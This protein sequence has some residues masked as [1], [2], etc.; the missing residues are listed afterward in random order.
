[1]GVELL[2]ATRF[3]TAPTMPNTLRFDRVL[4]MSSANFSDG[5]NRSFGGKYLELCVQEGTGERGFGRSFRAASVPSR[6]F[7]RRG[8]C[9]VPQAVLIVGWVAQYPSAT[10]DSAGVSRLLP[11]NLR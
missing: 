8:A 4:K 2:E 10:D 5:A 1:M 11:A 9:I 7:S 3:Q 6:Q